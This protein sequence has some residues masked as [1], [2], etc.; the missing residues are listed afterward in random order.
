VRRSI[1]IKEID[2]KK[3]P[4]FPARGREREREREKE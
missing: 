3:L 4:T 2:E 1:A